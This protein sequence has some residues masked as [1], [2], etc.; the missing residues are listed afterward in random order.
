MFISEPSGGSEDDELHKAWA[1]CKRHS[2]SVE[3]F[4]RNMDGDKVLTKIHFPFNPDVREY[5]NSSIL[6]HTATTRLCIAWC[7]A[8]IVLLYLCV[9]CFFLVQHELREEVVEKVKWNISRDSPEDKLRDLLEWM[10]AVRP[11]H[12]IRAA[13]STG[14]QNQ[15]PPHPRMV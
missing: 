7:T 11:S 14:S 1:L 2:K 3:I 12:G 13:F 4:Y 5:S 8:I 9:C 6:D 10:K 15:N